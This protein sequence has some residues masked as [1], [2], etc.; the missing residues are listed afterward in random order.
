MVYI[1]PSRNLD[2]VGYSFKYI[3]ICEQGSI[4]NQL[5]KVDCKYVFHYV[6]G[7]LC[8]SSIE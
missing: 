2:Y 1:Q 7:V 8:I 3:M 5:F 6:I 4:T